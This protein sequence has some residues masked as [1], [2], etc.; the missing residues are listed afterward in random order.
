MESYAIQCKSN[1]NT[2][3][4][5]EVPQFSCQKY[6]SIEEPMIYQCKHDVKQSCTSLK[7]QLHSLISIRAGARSLI[8]L[9]TVHIWA[10]VERPIPSAD[11]PAAPL[12]QEVP[13]KTGERPVLRTFMLYEQGALLSSEFLQISGREREAMRECGRDLWSMLSY[14]TA[15]LLH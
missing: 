1:N 14:F 9:G 2:S 10:V 5:T 6:G 8:I 4:F 13:V 12:V 7:S 15:D 3:S 11:G